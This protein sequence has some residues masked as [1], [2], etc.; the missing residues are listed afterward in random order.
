MEEEAQL[1]SHSN[2]IRDPFCDEI[3]GGGK[4]ERQRDHVGAA[5]GGCRTL[6][7]RNDTESFRYHDSDLVLDSLRSE[8]WLAS[9]DTRHH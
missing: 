7:L 1:H 4:R 5:P 3:G 8:G 6:A 2:R 9:S